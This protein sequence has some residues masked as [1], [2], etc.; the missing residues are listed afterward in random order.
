VDLPGSPVD[1][2]QLPDLPSGP[3]AA[4]VVAVLMLAA[5]A[6]VE[7]LV[8]AVAV[9]RLRPGGRTDYDRELVGQGAANAVSG[10]LGG[11]PV[12]GV[13]V[14]S[15]TNVAAGAVSRASTVLHGVWVLLFSLFLGGLVE[16]I[17]LAVL[18]AL[19]VVVGFQ[20]VKPAQIRAA[21]AHGELPVYVV[22]M[23][24][25]V[26][27]GLLEGVLAGVVVSLVLMLRR[28][29]R[30]H[31]RVEPTAVL[32]AEGAVA[33]PVHGH[34]TVVAGGT[35]SFLSVP[36]LS[37]TLAQIPAGSVV[38]L[39]VVADFLDHAVVDHIRT[40]K[41]Q[42]EATGGTVHVDELALAPRPLR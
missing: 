42:H 22:T 24:G 1:A 9:D 35:L 32:A 27:L 34:W 29:L 37:R 21:G 14:R 11:L 18:A 13:V 12:S 31:V 41:H 16:Q 6:S 15:S 19:L 30:A 38:A 17:P 8:C 2:V 39:H 25:V 28:V 20:L 26:V 5:V 23:A 3:W 40:W 7:T 10:L 36:R 33:A 4:A